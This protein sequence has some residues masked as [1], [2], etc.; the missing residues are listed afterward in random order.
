MNNSGNDKNQRESYWTESI[1]VGSVSYV[2]EVKIRL[3]I[4][5]IGRRIEEQ[6]AGRFVLREDLEF[7]SSDFELQNGRLSPNNSYH[8]D[9]LPGDSVG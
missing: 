7:Y 2:E 8:I 3:G 1:V 4:K 6:E 9:I 5:G